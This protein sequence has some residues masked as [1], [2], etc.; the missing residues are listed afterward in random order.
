[1]PIRRLSWP[2]RRLMLAAAALATSAVVCAQSVA[3]GGIAWSA[4]SVG[5]REALVPLQAQWSQIEPTRQQKWLEIAARFPRMSP[6]E[7]ERTQ[8]RMAEWARL[9]PLE[10]GQARANFQQARQLSVEEREERWQSYQA[11]PPDQ[12]K[13]L[14]ERATP[15]KKVRDLRKPPAADAAGGKASLVRASA[16]PLPLKPVAPT[17]VQVSPG[18]T[19]RLMS[20]PAKPPLHQQAGLPKIAATPDFVDA[21]TLLPQRGAQGAAAAPV[22]RA[23]PAVAVAEPAPPPVPAAE[24]AASAPMPAASQ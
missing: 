11:L 9:T 8:Q 12:K 13:E 15:P 2:P 7:R 20:R 6:E 21:S 3:G 1:M 18:T 5:Q 14:A 10:R 22:A 19:T 23:R 17:L 4:L 24:P 16:S